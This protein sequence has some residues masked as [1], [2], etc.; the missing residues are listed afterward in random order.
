VLTTLQTF[1]KTWTN[2]EQP[3]IFAKTNPGPTLQPGSDTFPCFDDRTLVK[4]M[5]FFVDDVEFFRKPISKTS[6]ATGQIKTTVFLTPLEANNINITHVGW[7]GGST[8]TD[9]LNTGILI[10]KQSFTFRKSD[11]QALQIDKT[12]TKGW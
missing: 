10:D 11:T 9:K 7:F 3:N 1:S 2:T 12:D 8:V 6:T 5:S 4:Y